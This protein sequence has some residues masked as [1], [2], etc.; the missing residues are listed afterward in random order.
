MSVNRRQFLQI[1]TTGV[2]AS[3]C[4]TQ[5]KA[6][7]RESLQISPD[8]VGMLYDSTLCIGCKACM[9]ACKQANG[10]P[11]ESTDENPLWDTP[12]ETSGSTL[13]VIKLYKN[14]KGE[15][16]D[17]EENGFAFMKR[18]CLHCVDPSCISVCPVSAMT[19]DPVTGIVEHH[20]DRCI[21]CRYCVY[22]CPF[23]I[24]KYEY[25]NAFGQIQKCQF[26]AHLQAEGKIPAC[27]DV[28]PTGATLFGRVDEL[29]AES[30]R[31]LQKNPGDHYVF[32]RG[33][34]GGDRPPHEGTIAQYQEHVYGLN[35]LGGTQIM[36]MSAIPFDKLGLPVNVPN[37]GY[38]TFAE[39]I[40]HTVYKWMLAPAILLGGLAY[41]VHRNT[42][43]K[44]EHKDAAERRES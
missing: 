24:P 23:G 36:Y 19:K 18:H 4:A 27:C 16:K 35:E 44:S 17:Q 9:V 40:Q 2:A 25:N 42:L 1:A 7:Q 14:G 21:G 30:Q 26:C 43:K 31:R 41:V 32:P 8:A 34:L 29:K 33:K 39:G 12:L 38:P 6:L 37:F 5:A 15:H 20:K 22:S 10:M 13:N 3:M 11:I 28:C